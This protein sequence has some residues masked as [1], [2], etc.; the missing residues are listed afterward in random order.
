MKMTINFDEDVDLNTD[1]GTIVNGKSHGETRYIYGDGVSS[2]LFFKWRQ[3]IGVGKN[4]KIKENELMS[5]D[6]YL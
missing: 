4:I 5:L 2:F 3:L 1:K 6:Y